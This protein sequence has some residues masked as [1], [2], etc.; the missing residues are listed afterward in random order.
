[1]SKLEYL[2]TLIYYYF[3]TNL[4]KGTKQMPRSILASFSNIRGSHH[5]GVKTAQFPRFFLRCLEVRTA[6]TSSD[7]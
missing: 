3:G 5:V 2:G 6:L 4:A 1:M 7:S